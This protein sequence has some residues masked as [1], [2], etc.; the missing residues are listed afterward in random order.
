M[1]AMLDYLK[2]LLLP[3]LAKPRGLRFVQAFG[4]AGDG[5]RDDCAFGVREAMVEESTTDTYPLHLRNSGLPVVANEA[6]RI[7]LAQ[8]RRRWLTWREAG[9]VESIIN[10]LA[11]L[12]FSGCTVVSQ[13][14]LFLS[15]ITEAFGGNFHYFY[16]TVPYS[17]G[18]R[19]AGDWDDGKLWD[20]ADA[21]EDSYWD[22]I[23]P[24]AGALDDIRYMIR[25]F[26]HGC[27]SCRFL[28]IYYGTG[29]TDYITTPVAELHE[30]QTY[31]GY[32]SYYTEWFL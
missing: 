4:Q 27:S 32:P 6:A 26:K 16:V 5:F 19:P 21:G 28:L 7:Q 25:K 14:D 30:I 18:F 15:G 17:A 13:L 12:G 11:R 20:G 29:P 1:A 8:V 31:G 10:N 24:Y 2:R 9:G 22:I 3:W 23:E